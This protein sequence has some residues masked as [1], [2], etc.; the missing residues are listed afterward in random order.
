MRGYLFD[1]FK[2]NAI[3]SQVCDNRAHVAPF[4]RELPFKLI[5]AFSYVGETV[6]DPFMGSGTTLS[7]AADLGRN[8]IGFEIVEEIA[9]QGINSIK[10]Y[11]VKLY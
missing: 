1:D 6:L 9:S 2:S 5:K 4:P 11:Q 3:S 8:G 10:A 7:V